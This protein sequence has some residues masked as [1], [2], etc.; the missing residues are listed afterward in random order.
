MSSLVFKIRFVNMNMHSSLRILH[1]VL[2]SVK[3]QI[4]SEVPDS[5]SIWILTNNDTP[6]KNE[7]DAIRIIANARDAME[8]GID[9]NVFPLPP[10]DKVFDKS[11]FYNKFISE[12]HVYTKNSPINAGSL[13]GMFNRVIRKIRKCAFLPLLLP[14]WKERKDD[15][16]VIMLDLYNTTQIESMPSQSVT[17]GELNRWDHSS[18]DCVCVS[19]NCCTNL[20]NYFLLCP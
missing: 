6:H 18:L 9:I 15:E 13:L 1:K 4:S 5:N 11:I 17:S 10:K 3:T 8:N 16:G 2:L 7:E 12:S 20:K 19:L 14:G